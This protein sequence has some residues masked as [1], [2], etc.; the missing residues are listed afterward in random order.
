MAVEDWISS[1]YREK[2]A[3]LNWKF[4]L[5][6][7]ERCQ[8]GCQGE[9]GKLTADRVRLYWIMHVPFFDVMFDLFLGKPRE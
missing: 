1:V 7:F 2:F 8:D 6:G 3:V 5:V 9:V 4:G